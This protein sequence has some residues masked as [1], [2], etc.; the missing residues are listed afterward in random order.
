MASIL[1]YGLII[2]RP[3]MQVDSKDV[4]RSLKGDSNDSRVKYDL[5]LQISTSKTIWISLL[6]S[7]PGW[8]YQMRSVCL[9]LYL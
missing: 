6:D 5:C 2:Y 8:G 3:V 4:Q 1:T 9:L 7:F